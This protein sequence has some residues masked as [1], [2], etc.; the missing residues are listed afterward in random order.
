LTISF[1]KFTYEIGKFRRMVM[2]HASPAPA[3]P[4]TAPVGPLH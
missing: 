4:S 2:H 3:V 1:H